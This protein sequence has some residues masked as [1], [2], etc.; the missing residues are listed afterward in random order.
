MSTT[1]FYDQRLA[2]LK[3]DLNAYGIEIVDYINSLYS[4]NNTT[5]TNM[6]SSINDSTQR[7]YDVKSDPFNILSVLKIDLNEII[8]ESQSRNEI[9]AMYKNEIDECSKLTKVLSTIADLID[10]L[11][12]CENLINKMSLIPACHLIDQITLG[13]SQLLPS[14]DKGIGSGRVCSVVKQENK[15]LYHRLTSKI[16]RIYKESV[17]F[18]Y[19][20]IIV[21]SELR[22]LLRSEDT[23]LLE[24]LLLTDTWSSINLCR[25]NDSIIDEILKNIWIFIVRPLWHEKKAPSMRLNRIDDNCIEFIVDNILQDY[26]PNNNNSSSSSRDHSLNDSL[27]ANPFINLGPCRMPIIQLLD[28]LNQLFSFL[29]IHVLCSNKL[30][31]EAIAV[32]LNTAPIAL[33]STIIE[34]ISYQ[35]PKSESELS[36]YRRSLE[37]PCRVFETKLYSIGLIH[38]SSTNS[39]TDDSIIDHDNAIIGPL[40][41]YIMKLPSIYSDLR[42]KEIL[43]LAREVVLS[44]YH[45]TMLAAGDA[46]EDD[47]SSAGDIGDA[48][49]VLDQS[50]SYAIQKLKFESCQV[51]LASCR[52]LKLIHDVMKQACLASPQVSKMELL[53]E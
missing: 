24:P 7:T 4:I 37:V 3:T 41:E 17:Q 45:N 21:Y 1:E 31:A 29:W 44:D 28:S 20:R 19:G 2:C 8:Q 50:G 40:T 22:G 26:K 38:Y 11:S 36:A 53:I 12:E 14:T 35:L 51:S 23:I 43:K 33:I 30:A 32:R 47:L 46:L 34:S 27:L 5:T 42:R 16:N 15:L 25:L 10:K 39:T 48:R 52:L 6:L 13:M 49:A 9:N 18:D